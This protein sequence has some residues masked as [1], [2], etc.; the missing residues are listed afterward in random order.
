MNP[1]ILA[2]AV[3][4]VLGLAGSIILVLASKFMAVYEDPRIAEVT[5]C[6][7]GANCGGCGYAG[8]ADYAKAIVED[9]APTFKCAPGGDKTA[10]AIN[11]IMG[12]ESSDRPS[13]R[14]VV[15]CNGG[16]NCQ[17]RFTYQGVQTCAA[18]AAVAGGPSACAYGCLGLGDC[19]RAC[20][21][22]A[23]HVV[24]GV[25]LVDRAKC[26]GCTA[27]VTA[28]PRHVID[29]KPIAPQP[30][31]KCS[32]IERGAAVNQAC[33]VGCIACGLCVKNCPQQAIFLKNNVAV[34]DYTKC[35]GCGTCVTKCPKKAIQWIEGKPASIDAPV[36]APEVR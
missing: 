7:A 29:M 20:M 15:L 5:A 22:D 25:A 32:N 30:V 12:A 3:L 10:D 14:A 2:V 34:I 8:C 27:C 35:N 13:L 4:A 26:T 9:G 33:K 17:Q 11:E 23:I 36:P 19:T 31:V 24:N 21:F 18:A 16:E 28:C 6:L 1:I